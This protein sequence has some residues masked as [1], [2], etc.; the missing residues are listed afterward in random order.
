[1]KLALANKN[2]QILK[3]DEQPPC[4]PAGA[5]CPNP[6]GPVLYKVE[7]FQPLNTTLD[8]KS[9]SLYNLTKNPLKDNSNSQS[10]N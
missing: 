7:D 10:T 8:K 3:K 5:N 2:S 1:M 6:S 4:A 9:P